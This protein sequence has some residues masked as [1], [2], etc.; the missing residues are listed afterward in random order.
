MFYTQHSGM[1]PLVTSKVGVLLESQSSVRT[2]KCMEPLLA[3]TE[4]SLCF[5]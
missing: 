3:Q 1:V 5:M 4:Q 2:V